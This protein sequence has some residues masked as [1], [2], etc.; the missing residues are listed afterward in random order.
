MSVLFGFQIALLIIFIHIFYLKFLF[1]RQ[2]DRQLLR[3]GLLPNMPE[4]VRAVPAKARSQ[5]INVGLPHEYQSP[6]YLSYHLLQPRMY[7]H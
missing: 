3:A 7:V 5:E 2:G 6:K 1:D 4:T